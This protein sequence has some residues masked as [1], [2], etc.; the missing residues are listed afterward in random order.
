MQ[1]PGVKNAIASAL[2]ED[3]GMIGV[4]LKVGIQEFVAGWSGASARWLHGHKD[5]VNFRQNPGVLELS[6]RASILKTP[7]RLDLYDHESIGSA[8]KLRSGCRG[9][10]E[11]CFHSVRQEEKMVRCA[12][13]P[14]PF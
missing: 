10:R 2:R 11:T 3:S 4:R 5:G 7:S 6:T 9:D 1:V 14:E 12:R 13:Q 8:N